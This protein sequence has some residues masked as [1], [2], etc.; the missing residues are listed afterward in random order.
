MSIQE[1]E[2]AT[3]GGALLGSAKSRNEVAHDGVSCWS[4]GW[5][6]VI[7]YTEG[8]SIFSMTFFW[9]FLGQWVFHFLDLLKEPMPTG[10]Y[11][12]F[13]IWQ[14]A[15]EEIDPFIHSRHAQDLAS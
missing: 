4:W 7:D 13:L 11:F 1:S 15:T 2:E 9:D 6:K 12:K 3:S 14:L 10:K 8:V 5:L